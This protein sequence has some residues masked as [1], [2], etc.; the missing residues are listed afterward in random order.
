MAQSIDIQAIAK[1]SVEQR[2]KLIEQ[3]WET[4]ERRDDEPFSDAQ[5][6]EIQR[7]LNNYRRNPSSALNYDQY[8]ALVRSLT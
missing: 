8:K 1:L 7:R 3:I 2:L 5:W 6:A 4:L